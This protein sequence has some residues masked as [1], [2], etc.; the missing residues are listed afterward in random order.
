MDC[1]GWEFFIV[2]MVYIVIFGDILGLQSRVGYF[3]L[4]KIL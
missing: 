4:N 2:K 1:Y 3:D